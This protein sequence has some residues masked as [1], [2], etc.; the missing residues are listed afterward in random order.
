MMMHG[1]CQ[2]KARKERRGT[3]TKVMTGCKGAT[4][5]RV[6][7]FVRHILTFNQARENAQSSTTFANESTPRPILY[8]LFKE[9]KV[10]GVRIWQIQSTQPF[11]NTSDEV[12]EVDPT[13]CDELCSRKSTLV[14]KQH[15]IPWCLGWALLC[16]ELPFRPYSKWQNSSNWRSMRQFGKQCLWILLSTCRRWR[17]QPLVKVFPGGRVKWQK[18]LVE[19]EHRQCVAWHAA[20]FIFS[21]RGL[22][23]RTLDLDLAYKQ[24]LVSK[25]TFGLQYLQ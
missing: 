15:M 16:G 17:H 22:Q 25:A 18:G 5:R 21:T 14:Q 8:C 23:G 12:Y 10:I 1:Y 20:S 9:V 4:L 24:I 6:T 2:G 13:S 19:V 3:T 11:C 7:Q